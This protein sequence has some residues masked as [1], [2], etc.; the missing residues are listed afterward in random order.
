MCMFN[1]TFFS[2]IGFPRDVYL[3]PLHIFQFI[4]IHIFFVSLHLFYSILLNVYMWMI[5]LISYYASFN[6]YKILFLVHN[7][8]S[9]HFYVI[10]SIITFVLVM[11][12]L[13]YFSPNFYFQHI[14]MILFSAGS[15]KLLLYSQNLFYMTCIISLCLA[16]I[17][18]LNHVWWGRK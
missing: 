10:N 2:L 9:L 6:Q 14:W 7:K 13:A 18:H 17:G 16:H 4:L 1:N 3:I 12:F 5:I 11:I 15:T 8:F